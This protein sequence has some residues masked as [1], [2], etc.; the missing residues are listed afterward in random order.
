LGYVYLNL[1]D[2]WMASKRDPSG[3]LYGDPKRFPS[4]MKALGNYIHSK[5]L[6]YGI[7]AS[8]GNYT[9]SSFPGSWGHEMQDAKT[10]ASWGVDFMKLDCCNTDE[11][12]KNITY[13]LWTKALN[14]TGRPIVYSCDTDELF[15]SADETPWIWGPSTCNMWRTWHDIKPYWWSWTLNLEFNVVAWDFTD[16]APFAGPGGWNDPDMLEVGVW[17][18]TDTASKAHFS[19]WCIMASPLIMG[20]DLRN[21]TN[22]SFNI[23]SNEELIAVDQDAG[24]LQERRSHYSFESETYFKPLSGGSIAVVMFNK[25]PLFNAD[26]TVRWEEIGLPPTTTAIVRDLWAKQDV[27]S[28]VSSFTAQDIAFSDV[29]AIK[30]TPT[31]GSTTPTTL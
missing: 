24:G 4:G 1:D 5:G 30:I 26:L 2:C 27:G 25:N 23:L 19:L 29:S 20:N 16:L 12:Q 22:T 3:N 18:M 21:M 31:S 7:Y 10:F 9:C 15:G 28:F 8:S 11:N 14:K 13:P 6:K 17:G